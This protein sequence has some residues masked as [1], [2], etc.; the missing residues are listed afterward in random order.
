MATKLIAGGGNPTIINDYE[1]ISTGGGI[2]RGVVS[3]TSINSGKV[4]YEVLVKSTDSTT[5]F[6]ITDAAH[7]FNGSYTFGVSAYEYAFYNGSK[8]N[9]YTGKGY[10]IGWGVNAIVGVLI[11][12]DN[13]V[14]S[15]AINGK[16]C[17]VAYTITN[18]TQGVLAAT[19]AYYPG[20]DLVFNFGQNPFVYPMYT[21]APFDATSPAHEYRREFTAD[22]VYPDSPLL[23]LEGMIYDTSIGTRTKNINASDTLSLNNGDRELRTV[24]GFTGNISFGTR[25]NRTSDGL[26]AYMFIGN[27]TTRSSIGLDNAEINYGNRFV[28]KQ[29]LSP[30]A[31]LLGDRLSKKMGQLFIP[32]FDDSNAIDH[33]K[34]TVTPTN[35][36]FGSGITVDAKNILYDYGKYRLYMNKAIAIPFLNDYGPIDQISFPIDVSLLPLGTTPCKLEYLF[37]DGSREYVDFEVNKD[38]TNRLR[39]SNVVYWYS[40]GYHKTNNIEC[41]ALGSSQGQ[42][43]I[44]SQLGTSATIETIEAAIDTTRSAG[45]ARITAD[46]SN[47]ACLFYVSFD[48]KN[49]WKSFIDG[50]WATCERNNIKTQGMKKSVLESVTS[51]QWTEIYARSK[52]DILKYMDPTVYPLETLVYKATG[53]SNSAW[54]LDYIVP[55][56]KLV[57]F[58]EISFVQSKSS[59][60]IYDT[61]GRLLDSKSVGDAPYHYFTYTPPKDVRIGRIYVNNNN[62]YSQAYTTLN[63]VGIPT[64]VYFKNLVAYLVENRPPVVSN[65]TL[66][67]SETH[68]DSVLSAHIKDA[69]GDAA[70]YRVSV[71]GE[72]M[73]EDF[74]TEGTE[75]DVLITILSSMTAVGT[76]AITIQTFD[77][78]T[79]SEPYTTYLTKVDAKPTI[80]GILDMLKL[81]A[82]ITDADSGDTVQYRILLNGVVKVDWTAFV[83]VPANIKYTMRNRDI[84]IGVQNTLTLEARD[85]LGESM[86]VDFDFVGQFYNLK[87][88]Y[89]YIL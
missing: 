11:D 71:N 26:N 45:V 58:F 69:E 87:S 66:L 75:Y 36:F 57:T 59:Y 27:K 18:L 19:R 21:Y 84:N 47:D 81:T 14:I 83:Q 29:S 63:V 64:N 68:T 77:G 65:V 22:V 5:G 86:S 15:A 24:N 89:A 78:L 10:G 28:N 7:P 51:D 17:G 50:A 42:Y 9:S 72:P 23:D 48:G 85:N 20:G 8:M 39:T 31:G 73:T 4:M 38:A 82:L 30:Y 60:N 43:Q 37:P 41:V 55:E 12:I 35:T 74:I 80:S 53:P 79:Y 52:L 33:V 46:C 6:G 2:Y 44:L 40:G 56:D 3:S 67:P 88:R 49:T 1:F 13:K 34:L 61:D 54:I 25:N 16:W 62:S 70:Y 32:I 76:N